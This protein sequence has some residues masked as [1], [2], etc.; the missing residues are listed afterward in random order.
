MQSSAAPESVFDVGT[1]ADQSDSV[2][3][4]KKGV[5]LGLAA[6]LVAIGLFFV[7]LDLPALES[8]TLSTLRFITLL[9]IL[10]GV[11]ACLSPI[12]L[13]LALTRKTARRVRID[14]SGLELDGLA[15]KTLR[16]AWGD[17]EL[18]FELYDFDR[19]PEPNSQT[20][21]RYFIRIN[22]RESTLSRP[23]FDRLLEVA[24]LRGLSVSKSRGSRW[25]Y[26]AALVPAVYRVRAPKPSSPLQS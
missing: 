24:R 7:T 15:G 12:P 1:L 11:A 23:A 16:V 22:R 4:N 8:G 2:K 9:I 10:S 19:L 21:P 25:V 13:G 18:A 26:S 20:K 6:F 3:R 17:P 5:L 14:D